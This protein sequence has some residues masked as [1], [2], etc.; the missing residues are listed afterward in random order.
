MG[1]TYQKYR[2]KKGNMKKYV[3]LIIFITGLS[4]AINLSGYWQQIGFLLLGFWYAT[5]FD[6]SV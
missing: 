3:M 6:E 2:R 4:I 5:M 1:H